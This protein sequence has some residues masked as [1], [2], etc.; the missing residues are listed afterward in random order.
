MWGKFQETLLCNKDF[1]KNSSHPSKVHN[2][3]LMLALAVQE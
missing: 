3:A 1:G 2:E